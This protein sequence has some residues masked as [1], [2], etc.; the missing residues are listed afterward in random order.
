M[1][2]IDNLTYSSVD[3]CRILKRFSLLSSV[4]CQYKCNQFLHLKDENDF[5]HEQYFTRMKSLK[6]IK[7]VYCDI[8]LLQF[9]IQIR[10]K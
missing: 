3:K 8:E 1:S 10:L 6:D 7:I 5:V 9:P 2:L 4:L